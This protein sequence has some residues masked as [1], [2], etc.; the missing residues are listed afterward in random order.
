M[1][2]FKH[3][4][5]GMGLFGGLLAGCGVPFSSTLS[6]VAPTAV[7]AKQ[8]EPPTGYYDKAD[9]LQGRQLLSALHRIIFAHKELGYGPGRNIMFGQVDDLDN[10]DV[11]I[12]VYTGK[13]GAR[14]TDSRTASERSMNA[15]HTWP[16]SKGAQGVAR[17][18]LHHLFPSD[19]DANGRRSSFPMG[20]VKSVLWE[21]PDEAGI[22]QHAR[23][24]D[25]AA[26][27]TVWEP[28]DI[29]KG[30]VAR[31]LLYFYTCYAVENASKVSLDNYRIELPVLLNW[32]EQDRPD[33]AEKARN[34]AIYKV[35][36]NRNPYIDH[37][38]YVSQV[39]SGFAP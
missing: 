5:V 12:G 25:D 15:E 24:G 18:D 14:I 20:M 17:S 33:M 7:S 32:H 30:N 10:D 4:L 19:M 22:N 8:Y 23:L 1:A 26:G 38:E 21:A 6:K 9:T 2:A 28:R 31:A 37:P 11:V 35:Q 34:E 36:G 13:P 27:E 3:W 29:E 39:G 16:Q